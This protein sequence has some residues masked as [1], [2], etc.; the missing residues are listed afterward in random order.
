MFFLYFCGE[1]K[2][3]SLNIFDKNINFNHPL[4]KNDIERNKY[5][6]YY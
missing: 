6:I 5:K 4:I 2:R 1:L 3:I